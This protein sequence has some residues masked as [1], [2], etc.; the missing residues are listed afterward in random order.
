V[1]LADRPIFSPVHTNNDVRKVETKRDETPLVSQHDTWFW[2]CIPSGRNMF[3]ARLPC[4]RVITLDTPAVRNAIHN[5]HSR[6]SL[7]DWVST[8][9]PPCR[10]FSGLDSAFMNARDLFRGMAAIQ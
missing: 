5:R 9:E 2:A 3:L 8:S 4:I 7:R 1:M 6:T 10:R